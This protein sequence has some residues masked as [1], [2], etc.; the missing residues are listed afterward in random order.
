MHTKGIAGICKENVDVRQRVSRDA[1]F[2][3]K[4]ALAGGL[5]TSTS[6]KILRRASLRD[7]MSTDYRNILSIANNSQLECCVIPL[8]RRA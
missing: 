6:I 4:L 5:R 8:T 1:V 3:N 7:A 2:R